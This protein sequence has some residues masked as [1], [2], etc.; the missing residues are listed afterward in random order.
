MKINLAYPCVALAFFGT[1]RTAYPI[2]ERGLINVDITEATLNDC[3]EID[4]SNVGDLQFSWL[5]SPIGIVRPIISSTGGIATLDEILSAPMGTLMGSAALQAER[6]WADHPTSRDMSLSHPHMW[7]PIPIAGPDDWWHQ[8]NAVRWYRGDEVDALNEI[9]HR[10]TRLI[11]IDGVMHK[12]AAR[13]G[14]RLALIN[15]VPTIEEWIDPILP[16]TSTE[17][18]FFDRHELDRAESCK[19]LLA[20]DENCSGTQFSAHMMPSDAA[21][22]TLR[23]LIGGLVLNGFGKGKRRALLKDAIEAVL[24]L[25]SSRKS[26]FDPDE[27]V[28]LRIAIQTILLA[29]QGNKNLRVIE[30]HRLLHAYAHSD[31]Y[32]RDMEALLDL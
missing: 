1:S 15:K 4:R 18:L 2:L 8:K 10:A 20:W 26:A 31:E 17:A 16:K 28:I 3:A 24:Q 32:D 14:Y 27:E 13:P 21:T 11:L 30:I 19:G 9:W 7:S 23:A 22:R 25:E 6:W 29:V 5:D 12:C